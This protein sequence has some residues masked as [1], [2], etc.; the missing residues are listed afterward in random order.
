MGC[1]EK[2]LRASRAELVMLYRRALNIQCKHFFKRSFFERNSQTKSS[3]TSL[4][5]S[6]SV[7]MKAKLIQGMMEVIVMPDLSAH[8]HAV[9]EEVSAI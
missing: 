2:L 1:C 9:G 3:T 7:E 4:K 6:C 5:L 8:N